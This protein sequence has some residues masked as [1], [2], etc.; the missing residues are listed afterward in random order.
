[1]VKI[2]SKKTLITAIIIASLSSLPIGAV[3]FTAV[4]NRDQVAVG[5]RL[6]LKLELSGAKAK[7]KPS[8]SILEDSFIVEDRGQSSNFSIIN[9]EMSSSI[10]WNYSLTP[11]KE[12]KI[13]IPPLSI[14]SSDGTLR[15]N[16]ITITVDKTSSL[17][18]ENQQQSVSIT[19][20][21]TDREPY[22]DEPITYT[23]TLTSRHEMTNVE[24]SKLSIDNAIVELIDKPSSTTRVLNGVAMNVIEIQY[25]ITPLKPG[26]FTIPSM[27]IQGAIPVRDTHSSGDDIF[28]PFNLFQGMPSVRP[29]GSTR[30]EPFGVAG[31][32]IVLEAKAPIAGV[33]PWLPAAS[34]KITESWDE[35]QILKVGEPVIRGFTLVARGVSSSR[36]PSLEAQQKKLE[37][38]KV[39]ADN[40]VLEDD[41]QAKSV[42]ARRQENYTLIPQQAGRFTLPKITVSWWN[43]NT[44][45]IAY[46]TVPARVLEILPGPQ[47]ADSPPATAQQP[48]APSSPIEVVSSTL[49]DTR[50]DNFLLYVIIGCLTVI[51]LFGFFWIISLQRKV[52]RLA[53]TKENTENDFGPKKNSRQTNRIT[54]KDLETVSS[55]EQ[56]QSFLQRYGQAHWDTSHNTS[57]EALIATVKQRFP[58]SAGEADFILKSL[59]DALYGDKRINI[60]ELKELC[61]ALLEAVKKTKKVSRNKKGNELPDLNPS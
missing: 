38:F 14:E 60:E 30:L 11:Q 12:G 26:N 43:V 31:N 47:A 25:L 17:P 22:K 27:V 58:E 10:T 45:R 40:P 49:G 39:Y 46:T 28:D 35:D 37:E 13:T 36:L 18:A 3:E 50:S 29:F 56:L 8:V 48:A 15:S 57:L 41:I 23:A 6:T 9:G 2:T 7:S 42:T 34:L 32:E 21:V 44:S 1:M 51:L 54:N 20:K 55:A 53:Q 59:Q 5:E 24:F 19:T 4:V 61:N 52:A 33:T 16:A